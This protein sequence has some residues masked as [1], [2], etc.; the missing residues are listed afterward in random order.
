MRL[1]AIIR[2]VIPA[3]HYGNGHATRQVL[4]VELVMWR[5]GGGMSWMGR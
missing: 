5:G 4:P 2:G 3:R 1:R